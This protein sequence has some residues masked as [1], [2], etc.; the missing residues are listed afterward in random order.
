[1]WPVTYDQMITELQ[2]PRTKLLKVVVQGCKRAG[3]AKLTFFC[4]EIGR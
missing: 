4:W 2:V 1:M 3:L